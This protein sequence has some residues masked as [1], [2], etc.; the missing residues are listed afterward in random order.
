MSIEW[1]VNPIIHCPFK[2]ITK[3][4]QFFPVDMIL[5]QFFVG[6]TQE[7]TLLIEILY[8]FPGEKEKILFFCFQK[9]KFELYFMA[10]KTYVIRQQI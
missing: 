1:S 10:Y 5:Y 3:D 4:L 9:K 2:D 7:I 6:H 8:C